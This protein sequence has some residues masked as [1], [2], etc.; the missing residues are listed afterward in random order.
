MG[1]LRYPHR[2]RLIYLYHL[3]NDNFIE[4][5]TDKSKQFIDVPFVT[6]FL[7]FFHFEQYFKFFH[8]NILV[9]K[10]YAKNLLE[11][12][13]LN[14]KNEK[15]LLPA[16][17]PLRERQIK[18]SKAFRYSKAAIQKSNIRTST[19]A[20]TNNNKN[21]R[22]EN[23]NALRSK[24]DAST[25]SSDFDYLT[26]TRQISVAYY[27]TPVFVFLILYSFLPHKVSTSLFILYVLST[28]LITFI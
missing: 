19:A 3:Q 28:Q 10:S 11:S 5:Q 1:L 14:R 18:V 12:N 26:K 8:E 15:S 2:S 25:Q 13:K 20:N 21:T 6:L 7:E 27:G 17:P 4:N 9:S 23:N 24:I 22:K 16:Q